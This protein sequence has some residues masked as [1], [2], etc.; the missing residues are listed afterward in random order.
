MLQA[1]QRTNSLAWDCFSA[2]VASPTSCPMARLLTHSVPPTQPTPALLSASHRRPRHRDHRARPGARAN[3]GLRQTAGQ[4]C[5]PRGLAAQAVD[6]RPR[7]RLRGQVR[8]RDH[9]QDDRSDSR[10]LT[11][12]FVSHTPR[13]LVGPPACSST[14]VSQTS[15]HSR[16]IP[17][18]R[19]CAC[20][21]ACKGCPASHSSRAASPRRTPPFTSTRSTSSSARAASRSPSRTRVRSSHHASRS[22]V[23]RRRSTRTRRTSSTHARR[24]TPR[25]RL[26]STCQAHSRPSRSRSSSRTTPIKPLRRGTALEGLLPLPPSIGSSP[27]LDRTQ[28]SGRVESPLLDPLWTRLTLL[29][30]RDG[31]ASAVGR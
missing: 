3:H 31:S 6:D 25:P 2:R 29:A 16:H 10:P 19:G 30:S 27:K 18:D 13:E 12:V 24:Q 1:A 4:R 22:G 9:R 11:A 17:T 14:R 8:P 23:A 26:A 7:R 28:T 5:A 15:A 20:G 21:D